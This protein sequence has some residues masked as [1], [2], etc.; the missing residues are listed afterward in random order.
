MAEKE[1]HPQRGELLSVDAAEAAIASRAPAP[2][3]IAIDGLPLSGK[4]TLADR[5]ADRF[6]WPILTLD[7][8]YLPSEDWPADIAPGFP[9]PFFR[10]DEFREAAQSLRDKGECAWRPIDWPTLTVSE[11][12]SRIQTDGPV[13]VEGCS[14]LDPKLT[15]LYDLRIFVASDRTTLVEAQKARDGENVLSEDWA[16]LFLPSVDIYMQTEPWRR[17]DIVVAG[18]GR[19]PEI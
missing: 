17:A 14:V 12:P 9:F 13:I 15:D 5:L 11:T 1:A 7:D 8:F 4:T 16:R 2:R 18:R 10:L 6:G 3:L 19:A